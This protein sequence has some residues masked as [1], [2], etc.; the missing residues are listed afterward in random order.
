MRGSDIFRDAVGAIV[1]ALIIMVLFVLLMGTMVMLGQSAGERV[2]AHMGEG[3][4]PGDTVAVAAVAPG[5]APPEV[6]VLCYHYL[7]DAGGLLRFLKVLG[8]VVL[9][10][11]LLDDDEIW[12]V[13]ADAFEKQMRTLH[14]EGFQ[15]VTL[16][17]L[18]RWQRGLGDLPPRPVVITFDDG[19]R[20]LF[21]IA[22]PILS[23]YGFTATAFVITN[24]V[25][26]Q[27]EGV[28][29]MSWAELRAMNDSGV[30]AI[31]SHSHDLHY[32]IAHQSS[33]APVFL[34]ASGGSEAF[35]SH[36]SWE[37]A[38]RD[39]LDRSRA[40]IARHIG[41]EPKFLAWPFGEGNEEVDRIAYDAGFDRVCAMLGGMNGGVD[42]APA[43]QHQWRR[44]EINRIP[45]T[46]R[47]SLRGFRKILA[48]VSPRT[49]T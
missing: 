8:Y 37:A 38:I 4:V 18:D 19:D 24:H 29:G 39:D 41:R 26:E 14:N 34:A 7:R 32:R 6:P 1:T 42:A 30:F 47:T 40:L 13:T 21:D 45:V 16:E 25:G 27:W 9:S 31:E 10:L 15:T 43:A 22:W 48:E 2:K 35:T 49:D 44:Q 33:S 36:D 17:Q 11:P 46:A 12:T 20:S 28:D 5:P 23:R 3:I